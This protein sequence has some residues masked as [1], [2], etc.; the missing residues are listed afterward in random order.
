MLRGCRLLKITGQGVSCDISQITRGSSFNV[1]HKPVWPK[2]RSLP[3][4][5][6]VDMSP[7]VYSTILYI[8]T[9]FTC[10]YLLFGPASLIHD[11]V[12]KLKHF[13]RYWPF[14]R[15][16]HRSPVNSPHKG[17][18]RD[19]SIFS[20]IRAWIHGWVNNRESGDLRRHRAH[21]D[22]IVMLDAG[23]A[24]MVVTPLLLQCRCDC[25][26]ETLLL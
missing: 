7:Y 5:T 6:N 22:I 11:D 20:L 4:I 12:I 26:V 15:G 21:Y 9:T 3:C 16:I 13:W 19:A 10:I 17:Q 8:S 2:P 18:W 23:K 25:S 24:R 1:S 14:E